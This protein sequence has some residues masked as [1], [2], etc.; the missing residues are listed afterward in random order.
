M[1][2]LFATRWFL[3]PFAFWVAN[4]ATAQT[5]TAPVAT[6]S[7]PAAAGAASS[8]PTTDIIPELKIGKDVYS[9]VR[10]T[11][12]TPLTIVFVHRHGIGSVALADLPPDLQQRFGY[13]PAKAAAEAARR[14][15]ENS[16]NKVAANVA[17]GDKG[18]PSLSAQQILQR[19]GQPPKIFA[20]VNMQP[21]FDQLGVGVKNQGP[22]PSCAVF[23]LVSALEYQCAPPEG[24]APEFSE[25]Y[26]IWA[27]L[28]TLGKTELAIPRNQASTLDLGFALTEVAEALR[29]YGIAMAGELPYHFNITDPHVLEPAADVIERSKKRTPVDGYYITGR[30]PRAQI[31]NIVQVLNAGV[32]VIIGISWPDQKTFSDN[33][34]LDDQPG[35]EKF[36]H[37][38]LLVSYRSK[39]GKL[40]DMQFLFKNSYGEKWGQN[41]YGVITYQYLTKNLH[42]A[43]FLVTH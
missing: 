9:D 5:A 41:G 26:L 23:A 43:L 31:S 10:V 3:W 38:V 34:M 40:D 36:G 7:A 16:A 15:A 13:D 19:F 24:P 2:Y 18:P 1:K 35:L 42:D 20:E 14:R 32:P 30:E 12:V 21:R 37:A 28:K 17:P 11:E 27:T 6:S 22:R 25:E 33:F 39:T 8:L 29:A 4:T